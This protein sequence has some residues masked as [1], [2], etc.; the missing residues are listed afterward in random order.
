M[1][2]FNANAPLTADLN[3]LFKIA[4]FVFLVGGVSIAKLR[5]DITKHG[6]MMGIAVILNTVS[7]AFVM[8]PSS[9]RLWGVWVWGLNLNLY[10]PRL[11]T[12]KE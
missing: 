7:I 1:R 3:L 12:E 11:H 9:L 10:L 2:L 6:V 8:I 5:C 4:I